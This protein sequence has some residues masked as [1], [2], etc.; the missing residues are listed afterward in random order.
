MQC[1]SLSY[2][3]MG[4]ND[5]NRRVWLWVRELSRHKIPYASVGHHSFDICNDEYLIALVLIC[6]GLL[7]PRKINVTKTWNQLVMIH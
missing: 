7:H 2:I 1:I 3:G 5:R 4:T 6:L